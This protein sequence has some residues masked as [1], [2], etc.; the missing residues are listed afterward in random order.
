[1]PVEFAKMGVDSPELI[2]DS[3]SL[4]KGPPAGKRLRALKYEDSLFSV[5]ARR[6]L[7]VCRTPKGGLSPAVSS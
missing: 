7:H 3:D 5:S 4:E 1:M 2:K 6:K